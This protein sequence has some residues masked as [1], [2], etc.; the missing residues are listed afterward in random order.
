MLSSIVSIKRLMVCHEKTRSRQDVFEC[1]PYSLFTLTYLAAESPEA[2]V[3]TIQNRPN[4][5]HLGPGI[6]VKCRNRRERER[7]MENRIQ[8]R[9]NVGSMIG[10]SRWM[11]K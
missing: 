6:C 5:A 1:I 3:L 11:S 2:S 8:K 10:D 9:S 4:A 7:S